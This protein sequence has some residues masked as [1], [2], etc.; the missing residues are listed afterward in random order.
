[1][2]LSAHQPQYL[3]WLGYFHKLAQ[4]DIFVFLDN[5]QYKKREFQNRNK[6]LTSSGP[7]WLTVPVR[8]RG[9]FEQLIKDVEIDN[10]VDWRKAHFESIRNNYGRAPFF[11]EHEPFFTSVY[12]KEWLKLAELNIYIVI[13]ILSYLEIPVK[14]VFES[15]LA[16]EGVKTARLVSI[17]K[18][19]KASIYLSG[20]GA[21]DYLEE[22]QFKEAGINLEYQVFKHPVYPQLLP[23]FVPDL[24]VIDLLFNRGKESIKIIREGKI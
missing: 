20:A 19:N 21:K 2:K 13:Y 10:S 5:V 14:V 17:C 8:T 7:L 3:P 16:A 15:A 9:K 6:I 11:K 18:K 1:M 12:K 24:S 4:S 23:G 22:E